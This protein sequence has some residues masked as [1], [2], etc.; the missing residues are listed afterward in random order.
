[1]QNESACCKPKEKYRRRCATF[2]PSVRCWDSLRCIS[3]L[4]STRL[5]SSSLMRACTSEPI[6]PHVDILSG[7]RE[8]VAGN[9]PRYLFF[10]LSTA[11]ARCF[12]AWRAVFYRFELAQGSTMA[13]SSKSIKFLRRG[14][15]SKSAPTSVVMSIRRGFSLS[16]CLLAPPRKGHVSSTIN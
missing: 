15:L 10:L 6:S 7:K 3:D 8:W 5:M 16:F 1:M 2:V 13:I 11:S 14:W 12:S 4:C 9:E